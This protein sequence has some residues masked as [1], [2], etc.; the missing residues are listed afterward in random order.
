MHWK[1]QPSPNYRAPT[2][3]RRA[4]FSRDCDRMRATLG[5]MPRLAGIGV[6]VERL[7]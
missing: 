2:R 6:K 4:L 1:K 7:T 5:S 3:P